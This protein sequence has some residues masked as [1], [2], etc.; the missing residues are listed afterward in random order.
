MVKVTMVFFGIFGKSD[1]G[2]RGVVWQMPQPMSF[3]RSLS[4]KRVENL[5][6]AGD[7]FAYCCFLQI[8]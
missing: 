1:L 6:Y 3:Y 4:K 2:A 5:L 7:L 8:A